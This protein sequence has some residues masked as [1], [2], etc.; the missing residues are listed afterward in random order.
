MITR[1]HIV[2]RTTLAFRC[3]VVTGKITCAYFPDNPNAEPSNFTYNK[4]IEV[5]PYCK[6]VLRKTVDLLETN[7]RFMEEKIFYG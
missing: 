6:N 7:C 3:L 4:K 2:H 1:N 5:I